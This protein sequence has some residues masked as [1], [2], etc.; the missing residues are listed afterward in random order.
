VSEGRLVPAVFDMFTARKTA[1]GQEK[2]VKGK[3]RKSMR[4]TV[5]FVQKISPQ[6]IL[7]YGDNVRS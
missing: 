1:A 4:L 6:Q 3:Y 7:K 5:K 2:R